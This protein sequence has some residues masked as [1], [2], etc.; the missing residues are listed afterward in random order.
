MMPRRGMSSDQ[1]E[2]AV[3]ETLKAWE[4]A[5]MQR[6]ATVPAT[7]DDWRSQ[8][9]AADTTIAMALEVVAGLLPRDIRVVVERLLALHHAIWRRKAG[10]RGRRDDGQ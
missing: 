3:L 1:R 6:M 10:E 7:Y 4:E 8:C 2:T 5:M 9:I